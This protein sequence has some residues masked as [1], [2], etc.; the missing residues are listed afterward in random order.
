RRDKV[1][2]ALCWLKRNNRYYAN[3]IID[4]NVLRTLLN[5]GSI[6]DLLPQVRDAENRLHHVDYEPRVTDRLDGETDDTI[7]RNFIPAPFPLCSENHVIDDAFT[8]IQSE[9]GPVM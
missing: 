6:D 9:T 8:R 5:K 1:R 7:I 3:I 2:K 4:D